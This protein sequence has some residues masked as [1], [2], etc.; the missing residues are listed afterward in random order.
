MEKHGKWS[1]IVLTILVAALLCLTACGGN[2]KSEP[3]QK[4]KAEEKE[5]TTE[6]K[7]RDISFEVPGEF[8]LD[9]SIT[10]EDNA[11]Y[12]LYDENGSMDCLIYASYDDSQSGNILNKDSADGFCKGLTS[13]DGI[14]DY[15]G[16]EVIDID[17]QLSGIKLGYEL[18]AN[19]KTYAVTVV[20][21]NDSEGH[22]YG[23]LCGTVD[24]HAESEARIGKVLESLKYSFDVWKEKHKLQLS[25]EF[26]ENILLDIYEVEIYVDEDKIGTIAQ[27]ET[28][29]KRLSL[30]EGKHE[31]VFYKSGSHDAKGSTE[32]DVDRNKAFSCSIKSHSEDI[33]INNQTEETLKEY[34][35]RIKKEKKQKAKEEAAARKAEKKAKAKER[36]AKRR[37]RAYDNLSAEAK[38]AYKSAKSYLDFQGFSRQGLIDQLSSEYGDAYPR[39]AAERAVRFMEKYD[40]VN[41][42]KQAKRVARSYL[43][44]GMS[45]SKAGLIQQLESQYGEKFTHQQAVNA[46]N[47]VY[48]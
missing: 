47:A 32:I 30:E 2:K 7:L 3:E 42:T 17:D 14:H 33:D 15:S 1:L 37:E 13:G 26:E 25:V 5:E 31:L 29:T 34:N 38:N 35:Q 22:V 40:G 45:F 23:I 48:K 19:D 10:D 11:Y 20:A 41:W 46:V 36:K 27:G 18:D 8:K 16:Y 39:K 43:D 9:E 28:F 12:K 4:S 44:S 6:V 21:F 24:G